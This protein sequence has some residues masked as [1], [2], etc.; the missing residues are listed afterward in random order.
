MSTLKDDLSV[1]INVLDVN[2]WQSPFYYK[3]EHVEKDAVVT[4][5]DV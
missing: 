2:F 1:V 4:Y 5:E 3:Y